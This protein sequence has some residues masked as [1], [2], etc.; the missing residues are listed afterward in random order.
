[1][2]AQDGDL[3]QASG[4]KGPE[5]IGGKLTMPVQIEKFTREHNKLNKAQDYMVAP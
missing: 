4:T 3:A 1:M 2:V 5:I